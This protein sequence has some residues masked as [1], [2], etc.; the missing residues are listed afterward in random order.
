V[1]LGSTFLRERPRQHELGLEHRPG[2]L[3]HAVQRRRHPPL[4]RMDDPTLHLGDDLAG[5][6]L[7]PVPVEVL[8]DG[9]ELHNE[10]AG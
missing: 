3:D 4:D 6:A 10:I 9:T 8:G 7:V 1:L 2:R 5:I